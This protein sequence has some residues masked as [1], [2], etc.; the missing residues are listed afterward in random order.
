MSPFPVARVRLEL[1]ERGPPPAPRTIS[2]LESAGALAWT[3]IC[4]S[5]K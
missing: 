3:C 4:H 1:V 2:M 5:R